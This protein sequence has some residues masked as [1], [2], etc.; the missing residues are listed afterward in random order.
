MK[1]RVLATVLSAMLA[2]SLLAACGGNETT[3]A[4]E[5]GTEAEEETEDLADPGAAGTTEMDVEGEAIELEVWTF[6]ELHQHFYV[7]MAERWNELNPDRQ[8]RLIMTNLPWDDMHNRLSLALEAGQGAP[9]VVDIELSRFPS[10]THGANIGLRDLSDVIAPYRADVVE[11]RLEL[12]SR[13][14]EYFGLPTH[15][16]ATVA[17]YNTDLLDEAGIDHTEIVTWEDFKNAG[18]QYYEATGR[19]FGIV[20]N[21]AQWQLGLL[22]AQLG[23]EYLDGDDNVFLADNPELIEAL[24]F[25]VAMQETGAFDVIPG[26]Q[27]DNAEAYPVFNAGDFAVQ[28]MPFWQTSRFVNYMT[29]LEGSVAI[30]PPPVWEVGGLQSIGGGGTGT[31]VIADGEHADLAAEVFAFIKLSEG[32]NEQVWDVI[33]FDP[34][35]TDV[36]T[37]EE[38]TRNPDNIFVQFFNTYPFDTLLEIKDGI[39]S[40]RSYRD[41]KWPSINTEIATIMLNNIFVNGMDVREALEISQDTLDNEWAW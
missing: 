7:E 31:A 26:G 14:G 8:V 39:G 5:V 22:L 21:G 24:E 27:P 32:S 4:P 29:D 20:E 36:W 34:V 38:L 16:G 33:G 35:N 2:L 11:S 10:F 28:I 40:L 41:E 25:L 9:D 23:G 6:I 18:I 13:D 1:K 17:F 30:A 19:T 37:D 12:Y 15:V 3:E